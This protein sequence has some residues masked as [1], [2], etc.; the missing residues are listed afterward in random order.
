MNKLSLA[1][2]FTIL[3][4]KKL[5]DDELIRYSFLELLFDNILTLEA[6]NDNKTISKGRNF[7]SLTNN[8]IFEYFIKVIQ[9]NGDG[10]SLDPS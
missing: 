8:R 5:T 1:E 2:T 7:N 10:E 4:I 9:S 6:S 3:N